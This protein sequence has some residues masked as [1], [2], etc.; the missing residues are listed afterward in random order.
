M[1][2]FNRQ[3]K[4]RIPGECEGTQFM[5]NPYLILFIVTE[6]LIKTALVQQLVSFTKNLATLT[7]P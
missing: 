7:G 1:P 3:A 6:F 4:L 5:I 2:F